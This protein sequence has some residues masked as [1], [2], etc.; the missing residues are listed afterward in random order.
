MEV[1][2]AGLL[3]DVPRLAGEAHTEWMD[4]LASRF[5]QP[6]H[7]VLRQPVDLHAKMEFA[8]LAGDGDVAPSMAEADRRRE[9]EHLLR[10]RPAARPPAWRGDRQ[11]PIEEV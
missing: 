11:A 2:L 9:I 7:R 10:C 6:R 3:L 1:V 8:Q 4:T 5:E